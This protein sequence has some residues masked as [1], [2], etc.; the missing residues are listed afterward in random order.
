M[1]S[2]SR[3]CSLARGPGVLDVVPHGV[4]REPADEHRLGVPG[5]E[6]PAGVRAAGLVDHRGALPGRLR[7][8][9]PGHL[10]VLAD[11]VDVAHLRGIGVDPVVPVLDHRVVVPGPLPQLVEHVQVLVGDLVAVVVL[12]LVVVA[13]VARG[14]GQVRGDHVPAD[15][16]LGQM[17]QCGHPAGE[18]E[19]R[20]VGGGEG[21]R[22]AEVLRHR[23][24]RRDHQ[25]RVVVGDLHGLPQCRL[26]PAAEPVVRADHIGQEHRVEAAVLQQL[27]Q[28][29]PELDV[30]ETVPVVV[31][32][33]PQ[34]VRDVPDAVHLEEVDVNLLRHGSALHC[35]AGLRV[36][37][38][39]RRCR[40]G[41]WRPAAPGCT[42][43]AARRRCPGPGR[44][45][46]PDRPSS[47]ARGR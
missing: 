24:H 40:A 42:D 36:R 1:W 28:F 34:A 19:R 9:R 46:P 15:P 4:Q 23:R 35:V 17:V 45:R 38:S 43:A 14:V 3:P 27:G 26:R 10:V 32:V 33:H 12:H 37:G 11:V 25:Q 18:G 20:L 8:V 13:E 30:V 22:E 41:E 44:T 7:Q 39:R 6:L 16:P 21:G 2:A 47:P 5:G 31:L 29:G